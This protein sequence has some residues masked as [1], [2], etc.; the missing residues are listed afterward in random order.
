MVAPISSDKVSSQPPER[1][2]TSTGRGSSGQTSQAST[3]TA[4][5]RPPEDTI[6]VSENGRLVSQST[7]NLPRGEIL[8]SSED[9][10][11]LAASLKSLISQN[12]QQAQEAQSGLSADQF[13]SILGATAA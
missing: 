5:P 6:E 4:D 2:T 3:A 7:E 11:E 12:P 1:N 13:S 10:F 8:E 9:A